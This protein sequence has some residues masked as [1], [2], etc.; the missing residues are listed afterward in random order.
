MIGYG[1]ILG[2]EDQSLVREMVV[3]LLLIQHPAEAPRIARV[4][5]LGNEDV[6][7]DLV[8]AVVNMTVAHIA[9]AVAGLDVVGAV[10]QR[11]KS[12]ASVRLAV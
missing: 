12:A 3:E 4:K 2:S 7:Q 1:S 8:A 9:Q 6:I 5:L 10:Q 11:P